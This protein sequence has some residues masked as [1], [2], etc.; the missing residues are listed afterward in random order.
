MSENIENLKNRFM[1]MTPDE[2]IEVLSK[3]ELTQQD[4]MDISTEMTKNIGINVA[5]T[6]LLTTTRYTHLKKRMKC[7]IEEDGEMYV[8]EM[9]KIADS[10]PEKGDR[11]HDRDISKSIT[12][13][14]DT[15]E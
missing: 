15:Y 11:D 2:M 8:F 7:V 13:T 6:N 10:N 3:E 12:I 5:M 1:G 9:K 4:K 14:I